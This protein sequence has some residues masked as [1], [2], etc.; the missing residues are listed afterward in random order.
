[1]RIP[2]LSNDKNALRSAF[3]L[4]AKHIT[5]LERRGD[6]DAWTPPKLAITTT[7]PSGDKNYIRYDQTTKRLEIY[8]TSKSRWL[9]VELT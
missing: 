9:G 5:K 2:F 4:I 3:E 7:S 1:M 6:K 8:D